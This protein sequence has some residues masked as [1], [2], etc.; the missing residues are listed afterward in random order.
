MAL[1]IPYS[2]LTEG[3]Y[4]GIIF[5]ISGMTCKAVGMVK[6]IYSHNNTSV[7]EKLIQLDLEYNI[8]MASVLVRKYSKGRSQNVKEHINNKTVNFEMVAKPNQTI[9][10]PIEMGLIYLSQIITD[11][12]NDLISIE[13]DIN[14]HNTKWFNSMRT[15]DLK[16]KLTIL[17][18]HNGLLIN[19][20][21][22]FI[23]ICS[24]FDKKK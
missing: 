7:N 20:Y 22:N 6:T 15:L 4:N 3:L 1:T 21:N 17:E 2:L 19:R 11:I 8:N 23:R 5:G 14:Y 9:N 16:K 13:S 12:H 24:T 18:L 10:D